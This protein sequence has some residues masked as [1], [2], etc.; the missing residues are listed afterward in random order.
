M[1]ELDTSYYDSAVY[2]A[3]ISSLHLALPFQPDAHSTRHPRTTPCLITPAEQLLSTPTPSHKRKKR[4]PIRTQNA[5]LSRKEKKKT[6]RLAMQKNA[7]TPRSH[8]VGGNKIIA[9]KHRAYKKERKKIGIMTTP[10][11]G[12]NPPWRPRCVPGIR[13]QSVTRCAS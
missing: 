6:K 7:T 10:N 12:T 1:I 11:T 3:P 8:H 4:A 5:A 13:A 9:K 2:I